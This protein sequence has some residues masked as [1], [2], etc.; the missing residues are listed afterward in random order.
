MQRRPRPAGAADELTVAVT[1]N[2]GHRYLAEAHVSSEAAESTK[3]LVGGCELS[4]RCREQL[5]GAQMLV[6]SWKQGSQNKRRSLG[7]GE[8]ASGC[9]AA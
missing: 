8:S 7:V 9:G 6:V 4:A 3:A 2:P 5:D 1:P